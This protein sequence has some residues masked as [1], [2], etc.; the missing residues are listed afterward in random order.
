L[1][2][3]DIN[4]P[5]SSGNPF[6]LAKLLGPSSVAQ[7]I[8]VKPEL[9]EVE[10]K[11]IVFVGTGKYLESS[12]LADTSTQTLYAIT[13]A[14]ETVTLNNPRGSTNMVSQS[15][16]NSGASRLVTNNAVSYATKRGWYIDLPDPGER[17]NVPSQLVFGTLLV[18]TIVPSNTVCSP[19]GYGWLNFVNF[20]TGAIIAQTVVASK[21]NAPIVGINILY[22]NG[23]PKVSVVTADNPTPEFP[24]IQPEFLGGTV[25]GFQD[26]RVIW[27]ELIEEQ[28]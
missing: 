1:W 9:S 24:S 28:Q 2:R 7:P 22:V 13:D 17:Q 11:R 18:P 27:R 16:S 5:Q 4:N 10:G 8:T 25:S 23:Q 6:K 3:F 12:D 21:T 14:N 15:I 26:R 19:G 20:K